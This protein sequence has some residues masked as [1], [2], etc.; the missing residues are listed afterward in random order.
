MTRNPWRTDVTPGGSSGGASASVAAGMV[1]VA[2]GGD[3][4]GSIRMPTAFCWASH[5]P[6]VFSAGATST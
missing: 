3:G 1:P 5:R 2:Q 4:G 6:P